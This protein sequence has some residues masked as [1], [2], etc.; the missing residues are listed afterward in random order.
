MAR[1]LDDLLEASRV[2]QD[3][4]ELRR[5]MLDLR[6]IVC[7]AVDAS[8]ASSRREI[9]LDVDLGDG[10]M[11]VFG[12]PARLQQ[13]HV[14]LL[15]NAAKYTPRGGHVWVSLV[16]EG[17]TAVVRVRD[18]GYGIPADMLD[19]VFD[20]F[21]QCRRT[22]ERAL[23]RSRPGPHARSL[24]AHDARRDGHRAQR[25]GEGKEPSSSSGFRSRS[26]QHRPSRR[27]GANPCA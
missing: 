24:A 25:E 3:K 23:G 12:D 1:L 14:N 19:S 20:L 16:R 2:T 11:R 15:S 13:V 9:H 17:D 26:R 21:V 10:E 27:K 8:R 5:S 6:T 18:D 7:D 4:I 22:L